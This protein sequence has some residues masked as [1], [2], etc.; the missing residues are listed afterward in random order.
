MIFL[1]GA[2]RVEPRTCTEMS[3]NNTENNKLSTAPSNGGES[4][5]SIPIQ[6][7][8]LRIFQTKNGKSKLFIRV[9]SYVANK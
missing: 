3:E 1:A 8:I 6:C 5:L 9:M 4:L 2:E 7:V